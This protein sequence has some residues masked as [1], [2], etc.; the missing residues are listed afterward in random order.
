M[1]DFCL[2][3]GNIGYFVTEV[4]KLLTQPKK[5]RVNIV[6]WREKRSLSQNALQHVIYEVVS[7]YLI[8]KGR[9]EWT[10]SK[11]KESLKSK[12]LGWEER[13]I[14]D[15]V[16]GEVIVKEKLIETSKLDVGESFHY[17]TQIIEWSESIGCEIK[18]PAKCEYR[19][20]MEQQ[21]GR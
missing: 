3:Q 16:T 11:V 13:E 4:Y 8:S 12:F 10:E 21:N 20:L 7:K 19:E 5:Y 15:V 17:T 2:T 6:E 1:K 18:I 14:I 9:I